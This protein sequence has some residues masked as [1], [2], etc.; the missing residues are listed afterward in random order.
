E[1]LKKK[2]NECMKAG[3]HTEAVFHYTHAIKIESK[4]AILYSNRSAAFLKIE[5]F[6]LAIQDARKSIQL[7]PNWT[8]V[9]YVWFL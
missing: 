6:Y 2:G 9:Q 4:N 7:D 8:K 3:N 1:E 5:Q